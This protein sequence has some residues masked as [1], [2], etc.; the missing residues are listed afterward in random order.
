MLK[1]THFLSYVSFV[2][3]FENEIQFSDWLMQFYS[4]MP[5]EYIGA[6]NKPRV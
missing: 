6:S 4:D 3:L 5:D 1:K 2:E